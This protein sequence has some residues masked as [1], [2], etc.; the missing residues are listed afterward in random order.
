MSRGINPPRW[1]EA[2]LRV[3]LPPGDAE[4]VSGD[5]L[6]DPVFL[7]QTSGSDW[8]EHIDTQLLQKDANSE[9]YR[10]TLGNSGDKK[11]LIVTLVVENGLL[12]INEVTGSETN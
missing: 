1:A 9:Q 5:L 10:V 6:E 12:K 8:S 7:A 11:V 3:S 2:L 4:T